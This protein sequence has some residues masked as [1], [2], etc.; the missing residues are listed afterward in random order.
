[1]FHTIKMY[2]WTALILQCDLLIVRDSSLLS[3]HTFFSVRTKENKG[4]VKTAFHSLLDFIAASDDKEFL[5]VEGMLKIA[6]Q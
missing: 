5:G 4:C 6:K 3:C 2:N 1:M